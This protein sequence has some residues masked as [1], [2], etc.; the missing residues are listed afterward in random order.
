[1]N[2]MFFPYC[3]GIPW[4]VDKN[5]IIKQKMISPIS[6]IV[7]GDINIVC[8]SGLMESY[9]SM[10]AFEFFK[11]KFPYHNLY[12]HGNDK[13]SSLI[14]SQGIA[15]FS[16][17]ISSKISDTYPIHLFKDVNNNT[18]FNLL[19]NYF[20]IKNYLGIEVNKN[21]INFLKWFDKNFM[22]DSLKNW[23]PKFRF[24]EEDIYFDKW[25]SLY[26]NIINKPYVLIIPD[27]IEISSSN[28]YYMN[29]TL[30]EIRAI[31][32]ILYSHGI[33]T[34]I[35]SNNNSN[36]FG[37]INYIDYN[38]FRFLK[39]SDGAK[40]VLSNQID[41]SI[42]AYLR[43]NKKIYAHHCNKIK[44]RVGSI[45]NYAYGFDINYNYISKK[46]KILSICDSLLSNNY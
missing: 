44:N 10:S 32:S 37:G 24:L 17:K 13:F 36:Y 35:M 12:W 38:F 16:N 2:K 3:P 14:K 33:Y 5:K 1:M 26:K 7:T 28:H 45:M 43:K 22:L 4:N 30:N 9:Y 40:A 8:H 34:I 41:F 23:L 27:K 15:S 21:K 11:T 39:I 31:S 18:Y 29:L 6:D 25:L 19:N 42:I 46:N 20:I